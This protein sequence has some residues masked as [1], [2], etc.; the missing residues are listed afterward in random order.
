VEGLYQLDST[1]LYVNRGVG[2][3]NLPLRFNCPPEITLI[4]LA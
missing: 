4:T 2:T 1:Q 3:V